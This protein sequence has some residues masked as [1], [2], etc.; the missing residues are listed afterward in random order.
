MIELL[1]LTSDQRDERAAMWCIRLADAPLDAEERAAFESWRAADPANARAFEEAVGIWQGIEA[2]TS[3]PEMIRHRA[4]AVERLRH[5]NSRR[6][7]RV[8]AVR[9]P[10]A[11]TACVLLL[12]MLT[13]VFLNG[14]PTRY[15][16][17]IGER[18]VVLLEDGSRMTLDGASAITV[19]MDDKSRSLELLSGRARFDVAHDPLRPFSVR[20][21]NRVTVATGT[22]F[23]VELL[24]EQV[25]VVLFEGRVEV[26]GQPAQ[27][28]APVSRR[29]PVARTVHVPPEPAVVLNPGKEL[30]A[31]TSD[32]AARI[33]DADLRH[34]LS[35][36]SGLL[37][38]EGEPLRL[39]AERMNRYAKSRIVV[40]DERAGLY[41]ISGVF[42]AGDTDAFVEG[43]TALYPIT[44][45]HRPGE[46]VLASR[47]ETVRAEN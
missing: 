3:T 46:I 6:W 44:V 45:T 2:I 7:S 17:A 9:W 1:P 21:R 39:A 27:N 14:R 40:Q 11:M 24:P 20:A 32:I 47:R 38:F 19:R 15:E 8:T 22:S 43:V 29:S 33:V 41:Q 12:I 10:T 31:S 5:L 36:E 42:E 30:I 25:R 23:S 35:W 28:P 4:Q 37:S 16:T 26:I 18:R 34:A 13:F